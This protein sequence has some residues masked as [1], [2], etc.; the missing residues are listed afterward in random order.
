MGMHLLRQTGQLVA[1]L[2]AVSVIVFLS[3]HL[4]PGDPARIIAGEDSSEADVM[5]VR[6]SLGLDRSLIVQYF[7]YMMNLFRGDLGYSYQTNR[8]VADLIAARL[9]ATITLGVSSLVF[10]I[11]IGIPL[12]VI[13]A[14]KRKTVWDTLASSTALLGVSI[15]NFWLGSM[16]ILGFAVVLPIF[17]VAGLQYPWFTREGLLEL[18]LPSI[19]LGTAT[20]ALLARM[21][22]SS[23]LEVLQSDFVRTA[24]SKGM[25]EKQV[26]MVHALRNAMIPIITI[27]GLS[28]GG[29]LSGAIVTEQVFAI[30]GIGQ[31]TVS[32]LTNRDFPVIQAVTLMMATTFVLVNFLVDV[33]YAL[34]DPRINVVQ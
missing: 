3:V 13:A 21:T 7:D 8:P 34:V 16:L 17:P 11:V 26:I 23:L 30:N 20:A 32:A 12:G 14:V 18:V 15:P 1:V 33:V 31:L 6:E 2:L 19:T 24:R 4:V 10:A 22:R 27:I 28:F 5:A 29:I 25:P 9:P